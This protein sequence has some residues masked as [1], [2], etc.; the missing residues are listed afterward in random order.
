MGSF[1]EQV[2]WGVGWVEGYVGGFGLVGIE[3]GIHSLALRARM[4]LDSR[5]KPEAQASGSCCYCIIFRPRSSIRARSASERI[6]PL[7]HHLPSSIFDTS[8]KRKRADLAF[9]ASSSVLDFRYEPEAQASGSCCYCIIFRPRFSIRARSASERILPLSHHLPS[10][11]FD[12]SP[13]RKRADL[14]F[15][16][17]SSVLDLRYE[18][19]AQARGWVHSSNW[20]FWVSGG[21][22]DS[23]VDLFLLEWR[24]EFT[25]LRFGLVWASIFDTSPKRKRADLAVIASSSVL[26]FRYEPEAQA[27]GSCCYCIIF[28]PRSSI[29][30]RSASER[31]LPL[32]H[33]LPS[34]IFNTSP[35]RKRADLAV[36]A[37]SSGLDL[38]YEP[39]AQASGSCLYRILL[40]PRFSLRA[41]SASERL[42][43]FVELVF[44][45]FGWVEG[46][47]G[48]FGLVGIEV[49]IHSLALRAR[50]GLDSRYKPEAQ[51][52][53]SCCYCIIF[54]PRFSIQARSAGADLALLHHLP[55]SIFDTS[56][57]QASG[58]CLYRI[59]FRPRFSIRARS[60]S[61]RIL[62]L[63]HHLPASIFDTSPKRKRADLA[64]IASSSVL[65]FRYEPEAQASGSCC[66][67]I[68]FRPRFSIRAQARADLAFI[69]SSSVLDFRYEPEAQASGSCLYRIIFRPR[70]SIR[71]RSASERLGSF[72][73]LVFLGFGWVEGFV[74]G[75]V[76]VGMEV[77]IHSLAL[78]ARMGLDSRYKPEVQASGSCCY[79]IIF[80]PRFSIR[81]G[82]CRK[83]QTPW[84]SLTPRLSRLP[85]TRHRI[86]GLFRPEQRIQITHFLVESSQKRHFEPLD[87]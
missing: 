15:I 73:E 1:V 34:S 49:G 59:I 11:I 20:F 31:I 6:L 80:R 2:F 40:R 68:I 70:S 25:R 48:G 86:L 67:C 9:I 3:V 8:P 35:K 24:S 54:R 38:Q 57:K 56:P 7:S 75:F 83:L 27:S 39:E 26:D 77:G 23:S 71:A 69:T 72:V 74:G 22:K 64:F 42:G 51:A 66:Y 28:R 18:P 55:A 61:E 13:K 10:S 62:L 12:T 14:A 84:K 79:C 17:S 32:S 60:A 30:A 53:G 5:Y 52:S 19:E 41:R 81:D 37:S 63:L 50:M 29:R 78:R 44:L 16:A 43:S 21:L 46:Y 76:L 85:G 45:G 47:V 87:R 36:I 82:S 65:D 4:G 58:S 33:H